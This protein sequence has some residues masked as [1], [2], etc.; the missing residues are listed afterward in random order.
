MGVGVQLGVGHCGDGV[1]L[2]RL[3]RGGCSWA[4]LRVG[5]GTRPR[6]VRPLRGGS[7]R[8]AALHFAPGERRVV[9]AH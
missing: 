2:R 4:R 1:R 9:P 7:A 3:C 8:E 5:L 6:A